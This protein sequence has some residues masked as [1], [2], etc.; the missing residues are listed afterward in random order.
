MALLLPTTH[1]WDALIDRMGANAVLS[2]GTTACMFI[3]C[4]FFTTLD[5]ILHHFPDS[6]VG[7]WLRSRKIQA[8]AKQEA[9]WSAGLHVSLMNILCLHAP[10]TYFL[11][12]PR[13][14]PARQQNIDSTTHRWRWPDRDRSLYAFPPWRQA[15]GRDLPSVGG[16]LW[17]LWWLFVVEDFCAYWLHWVE[18]EWK[19]LY[20]HSHKWHHSVLA[21]TAFHFI[22]MHPLEYVLGGACGGIAT[23]CVTPHFSVLLLFALL[24]IWQGVCEHGGYAFPASPW[25]F[26]PFVS[27]AEWHDAHHSLNKG[28]NLGEVFMV[29]DY[30][31]GTYHPCEGKGSARTRWMPWWR[32]KGVKGE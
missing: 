30:I 5:A 10:M 17:Q 29:W 21:P 22:Y 24:R 32:R 23:L 6:W 14:A 25:A 13:A 8:P 7:R 28:K 15:A 16:A 20:R 3:F 11:F 12:D 26:L 31:A 4:F 19:F 9:T 18:H 1:Q 27:D 2:V